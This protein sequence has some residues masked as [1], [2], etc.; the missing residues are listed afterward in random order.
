MTI[1]NPTADMR[2]GAIYGRLLI[3]HIVTKIMSGWIRKGTLVG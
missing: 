3:N 2:N 1:K